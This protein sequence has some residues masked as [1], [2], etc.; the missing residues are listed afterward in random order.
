MLA[1][2]MLTLG[3][4]VPQFTRRMQKVAAHMNS[5]AFAAANGRG[6]QGPTPR[7]VGG[8][9]SPA[10]AFPYVLS[11]NAAGNVCGAGLISPRW[12]LTAAHCV[13][14]RH[15]NY[16]SVAVHAHNLFAQDEHEC[17]ETVWVAQ[18]RS[19]KDGDAPAILSDEEQDPPARRRRRTPKAAAKAVSMIGTRP[20]GALDL[21]RWSLRSRGVQET[22]EFLDCD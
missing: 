7:I 6:L 21:F 13:A 12:A 18:K 1:M 19:R 3:E 17:S 4:T 22:I 2:L 16:L 10:H 20:S 14:D 15:E 11:L 8:V 5:P 9:E